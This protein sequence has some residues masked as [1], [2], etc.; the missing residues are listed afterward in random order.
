MS[1][2]LVT[3]CAGFI[4]SHLSESLLADG[5]EVVGV[6]CFNENYAAEAKWANLEV[7]RAYDAFTLRTEDLGTADLRALL[8]DCDT[9]FH[10]AA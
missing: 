3:G 2:A 1:R 8:A 4:G 7:A 9:A 6:D 5:W 10:L